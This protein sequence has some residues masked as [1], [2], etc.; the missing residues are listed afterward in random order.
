[1][2]QS[3]N[4]LFQPEPT[5]VAYNGFNAADDGAA[6]RAA[7]KGLGTDEQAIID[8]LTR[9]S[10]SQRQQISKWFTEEFGRVTKPY[11]HIF[12][13]CMKYLFAF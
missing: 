9:R 5:V 4:D 7:M 12:E 3:E 1:M 10:N 8:I 13:K 6:L 11:K 2:T